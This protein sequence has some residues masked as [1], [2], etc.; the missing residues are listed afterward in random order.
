MFADRRALRI[1][2]ASSRKVITELRAVKTRML[3]RRGDHRQHRHLDFLLFDLL[4]EIFRR[5]AHHQAGDEHRQDAV[6]QN[7]VQAGAHAAED[8]FA[9]HRC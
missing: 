9:G 8:D 5:A 7:A 4:A 2:V 6:E 1:P 3:K